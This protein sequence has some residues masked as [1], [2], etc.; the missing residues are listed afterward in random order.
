MAAERERLRELA[1]M[2]AFTVLLAAG[3]RLSIPCW[4][5]P[6]T[7]QTLV[8]AVAGLTLGPWRGLA[9]VAVYLLMGLIGLPVFAQG[10]GSGYVLMPGFG[11]VLGFLPAVAVTGLLRGLDR[12]LPR[13]AAHTLAALAG[14]VPLYAVGALYYTLIKGLYGSAPSWA[15]LG[16]F[17]VYL[18]GDIAKALAAAAVAGRVGSGRVSGRNKSF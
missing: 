2:A 13:F 16:P 1:A 9:V 18:P 7:L 4:P 17:L 10:G 14:L 12:R 6:L 5:A 8:L 15:I 11:F 3:A